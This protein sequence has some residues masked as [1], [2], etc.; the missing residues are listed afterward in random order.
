MTETSPPLIYRWYALGW[1]IAVAVQTSDAVQVSTVG[2]QTLGAEHQAPVRRSGPT[3]LRD[4]IPGADRVHLDALLDGR[5]LCI[6]RR[7]DNELERA[8]M[9]QLPLLPT[10]RIRR[11]LQRDR[12]PQRQYGIEA[13][14]RRT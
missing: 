10:T 1:T 2:S 13:A 9:C 4:I 12:E 6:E 7:I 14:S 5:R 3:G 8:E 11:P